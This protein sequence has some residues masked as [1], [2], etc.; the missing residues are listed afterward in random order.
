MSDQDEVVSVRLR[1]NTTSTPWGFRMQGGHEY[2]SALFIQTV[3]PKSLSARQGLR[4]GDRLLAIG[5]SEAHNMSHDQAKMEIIRAG[6]ELDLIVQRRQGQHGF[7]Q[8][9]AIKVPKQHRHEAS[10][11]PTEYRGYTNPNVQSR[12]FKILKESL[13]ISDANEEGN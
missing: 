13:S 4:V 5:P 7:D 11:E 6:N 10:E 3:S 2:G 1:R 12:S 9:D 8:T